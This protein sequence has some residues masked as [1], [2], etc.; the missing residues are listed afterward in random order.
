MN[1]ARLKERSSCGKCRTA[2]LALTIA[3]VAQI[4]QNAA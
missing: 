3:V 4:I 1:S 2:A